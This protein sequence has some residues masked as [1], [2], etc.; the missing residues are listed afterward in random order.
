MRTGG[1]GGLDSVSSEEV[2]STSE[3]HSRTGRGGDYCMAELN[4]QWLILDSRLV[5]ST[6]MSAPEF[7]SQAHRGRV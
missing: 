2:R 3:G 1:R 7:K 4:T 5:G 6:N